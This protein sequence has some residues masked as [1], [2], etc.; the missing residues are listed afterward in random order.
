MATLKIISYGFWV[1]AIFLGTLISAD[2]LGLARHVAYDPDGP[3]TLLVLFIVFMALFCGFYVLMQ[4]TV[5]GDF[6]G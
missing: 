1:A 3:A 4:E 2:A 6:E 5:E